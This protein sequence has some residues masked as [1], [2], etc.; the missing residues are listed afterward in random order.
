MCILVRILIAAVKHNVQKQIDFHITVHHQ[1][2]SGQE[3]EQRKNLGQE[4][5]QRTRKGVAY[6]LAS[7][8]LLNPLSYRPQDSQPGDGTTHNALPLPTL[9]SH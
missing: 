9:I 7:H 3:L 8:G 2:K 1:R 6:W 5:I 4:L